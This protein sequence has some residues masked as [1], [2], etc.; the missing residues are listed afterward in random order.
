MRNSAQP[1]YEGSPGRMQSPPCLGS[2]GSGQSPPHLVEDMTSESY[3]TAS[4][5]LAEAAWRYD[6][7]KD[8]GT[9]E[10]GR[11]LFICHFLMRLHISVLGL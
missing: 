10:I 8:P 1:S 11:K 3:Q 6:R 4:K 7:D 2:P 9:F 5:K